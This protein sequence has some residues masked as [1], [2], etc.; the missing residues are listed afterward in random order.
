[1][2]RKHSIESLLTKAKKLL[3]SIEAEYKNSL[4]AK[5][6]GQELKV[7]IKNFCENLRSV[8]DYLAREIFEGYCAKKKRQKRLYF[9]ISPDLKSFEVVIA[10]FFPGL[11]KNK[12]K[13]CDYLLSIQVFQKKENRWLILFNKLNNE[14]KH[15][16]LVQQTKTESKRVNVKTGNRGLVSWNPDSVKFGSGILIGGVLVDPQTQMPIPHPLQ[17]VEIVTWVD[18]KFKGIDVS[19]LWLLKKSL[20]EIEK[21]Y[22]SID[23]LT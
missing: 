20:R 18:F 9:P 23:S 8:L 10:R 16:D 19:A 4:N 1:M 22:K 5:E 14:N 17:T 13:L 15:E 2:K 11:K 3:I 12:K 21:I 6:I 7:D